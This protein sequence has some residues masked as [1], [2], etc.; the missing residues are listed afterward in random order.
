MNDQEFHATET[1]VAAVTNGEYVKFRATKA[2]PVWV[3]TGYCRSS[4][5]YSFE[6]TDDRNNEIFRK[7]DIAC[8]IGFTY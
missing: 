6:A 7:G 8:F 1:T 3:K 4:K 5:R 2:A